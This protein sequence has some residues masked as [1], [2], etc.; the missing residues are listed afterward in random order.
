M[1]LYE[2][3]FSKSY[4][5]WNKPKILDTSNKAYFWAQMFFFCGNVLIVLEVSQ[6]QIRKID[7]TYSNILIFFRFLTSWIEKPSNWKIQKKNLF[8]SKLCLLLFTR[9]YRNFTLKYTDVWLWSEKLSKI[10]YYW[11]TIKTS[12][13]SI[14]RLMKNW[15]IKQNFIS[16]GLCQFFSK[17][18]YA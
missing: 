6:K 2:K 9:P 12:Y 17:N 10:N 11:I 8:F 15:K 3:V 1:I 14:V 4:D 7:L 18:F 13:Y 16:M 5:W